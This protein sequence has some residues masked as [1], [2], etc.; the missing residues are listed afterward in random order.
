MTQ[1]VFFLLIISWY[2]VLFQSEKDTVPERKDLSCKN[3]TNC[4]KLDVLSGR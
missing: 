3:L 1:N 4:C 2:S